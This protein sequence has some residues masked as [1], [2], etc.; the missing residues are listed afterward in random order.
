MMR[1]A[2]FPG[3]AKAMNRMRMIQIGDMAVNAGR[4]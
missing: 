3:R 4:D 1:S 2:T